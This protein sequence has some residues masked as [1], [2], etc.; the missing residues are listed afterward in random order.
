MAVYTG[1]SLSP[2]WFGL[3]FIFIGWFVLVPFNYRELIIHS[4]MFFLIF[5][6]GLF[7]QQ[8]FQLISYEIAKIVFLYSGTL[9]I[10]FY[11]AVSRNQSDAESFVLNNALK[12]KNKELNKYLKVLEQAPGSV[13]I[14][15]TK[16]N[17]EYINPM[18]SQLS[19]YTQEELL[20]KNINDTIYQGK[21]PD[22]R[23]DVARAL[24]NGEKWQGELLTYHKEG[25]SYW[26]NTIAAPY[27]DES[28]NIEGYIVIQQDITARKDMENA[29]RESE[30]LYRT[31][32]EKS[33]NGVSLTCNRRFLL[34]NEAF[35]NILG[36][37]VEEIM[38]I[39]PENLLAPEERERILALHDKRMTGELDTMS[40][41]ARFIHKSGKQLTVEMNST[42]VQVHGQNASFVTLRDITEQSALKVALEKSEAKYKTLVENS[43][44]G[45]LIIRDDKVL[46]A[47]NTISRLLEYSIEEFYQMPSIHLIHPDDRHKAVQIANK[48]HSLDFSTINEEFRMISRN[49]EIK[50]CETS[51]SLI[52]FDGQWA[53]FFTIQDIT[54]S[55]R[56]QTELK[57]KEEKYRQLFDAESDAIF[58]IDADTGEILDA[59]PA[60][61]LTYGYSH[62]ELILMKNTDI[63]AEPDKTSQATRAHLNHVPVRYHKKKDG[64]VFPVEL[65]AGFT[66]I[67]NRNIQI[68][69]SRDI[70]ERIQNQEA[71]SKS[72]QKYREL[73]ELLPQAI[74]EHDLN[75]NLTFLNQAGKQKFGIDTLEPPISAFSLVTPED[76]ERM[77]KNM[78]ESLSRNINSHGN[79][80]T[81]IRT[82]GEKFPV[83]IFASPMLSENNMIGIPGILIDMTE[84]VA[85][86]KALRESE[87]KYRELTELLPQAI[88]E[89]DAEG[90]P[91]YMNK[92][93]LKI[94]GIE[95]GT[96]NK[97]AFDFFIPEDMQRMKQA[98]KMESA[99]MFSDEGVPQSIPSDPM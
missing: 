13:L 15:D 33:L 10:G 53:S 5:L 89:L 54:E 50:D 12:E 46:F 8:K 6:A 23:L 65:S 87:K 72:E 25:K 28:G 48:R 40:Y 45:I 83:M 56:M 19:G 30:I 27:K 18:F 70:T 31:L 22:S 44:D 57:E 95:N 94:F 24:R 3:F 71:L 92:A 81:A 43:K 68:V 75:G 49:G 73:T 29:L 82:N 90:N 63:S 14:M 67:G 2:Y 51:S 21:T 62:D 59:N 4:L 37:S 66:R 36:Y 9:F 61:S 55:K 80:Y 88:Y 16:M 52:E 86:E 17:F 98:L 1:A 35:C 84:Q 96:E 42:T 97:K 58:M 39:Q 64:T 76:I 85:I 26:A 78:G 77:R 91:K 34:V 93:G 38:E 41:E 7:L 74:Y 79:M 60:T 20:H 69:T 47:N 11:A 99:R 32:I